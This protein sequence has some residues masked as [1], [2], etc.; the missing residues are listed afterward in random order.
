MDLEL[1]NG[2]GKATITKL[3]DLRIYSVEDLVN[4]LPISYCD[5]DDSP[6]AD[7][8]VIGDFVL[9]KGCIDGL[10]CDYKKKIVRGKLNCSD[11]VELIWF[12][13]PYLMK[14]ITQ[15][16]YCVYGKL[17]EYKGHY[18]IS[19]PQIEEISK[20]VN[21]KGIQPIYRLKDKISQSTFRKFVSSALNCVIIPDKYIDNLLGALYKTHFPTSISD[22]NVGLRALAVDTLANEFVHYRIDNNLN[23]TNYKI[24]KVAEI[25]EYCRSLPYEL[26]IS[27]RKAID[28]VVM[29]LASNKL[30]NRLILGDVGT[31]KSVIAM[32]SM[33]YVAKSGYQAVMIAPTEILARQHYNTFCNLFKF[34]SDSAVFLSG[35]MN[36]LNKTTATKSIESGV[37]RYIF[38]THAAISEDVKYNKLGLAVLDEVQKFGV[39]QKGNLITRYDSVDTLI[40]SATPLPRSLAMTIYGDLTMSKIYPRSDKDRVKTYI[41]NI[42]KIDKL[43]KYLID[44]V[45][46]GQQAYIVCPRLE[47]NDGQIHLSAKTLYDQL[48]QGVFS[49]IRLGLIFGS[50]KEDDKA[51]V[52][53]N[54][55]IGK[56]DVLIATSVI[57]VGIDQPNATVIVVI[58]ANYFGLSTL[59]QLRGRVGRGS[60]IGEAYFVSETNNIPDR[61]RILS[62]CNDGEKLSVFDAEQRGFGEMFGV[63][64]SGV[65]G[66]EKYK[67][68]LSLE[69]VAE[70]KGLADI[71]IAKGLKPYDQC[72]LSYNKLKDIILN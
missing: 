65:S 48:S 12:N 9:L 1:I 36:S 16:E 28:D 11:N 2:V 20:L 21:L 17:S 26:T 64:Q 25:S 43:Y 10:Y 49:N 8:A 71:A 38:A 15:A 51:E 52:M 60:I 13:Q 4:F 47:S 70:A 18:S 22:I 35:K 62:E 33:I 14:S 41:M 23:N 67:I 66:Y 39:K 7:D 37:S 3:N 45:H 32:L 46:L 42:S 31:G 72:D 56:I 50:M 40:M 19:N 29:E 68:P 54:Y 24:P 58:G 61:L 69:L 27:Q 6:G 30:M 34:E 5:Y 55:S 63:S 57:E 59:H 44:R 53:N